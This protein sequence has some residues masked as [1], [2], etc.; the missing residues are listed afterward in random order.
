MSDPETEPGGCGCKVGRV[1]ERYGLDG[2]DAE[3]AARWTVPDGE[4]ASL[5]ELADEFNRRVAR[6]ALRAAGAEPIDGEAANTYRVLDD[7][8]VSS[9]VRV[10]AR[11]RLAR[12]GVDAGALESSFVSH[13]SL[14]T[15]FVDCL[16]ARAPTAGRP[17][18][19]R[20]RGRIDALQGRLAAVASDSLA[21]LEAADRLALDGFDVLV[22][23]DVHCEACGA[24]HDV[25][26]VLDEGGCPRQQDGE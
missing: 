7:G 13:Q 6:A 24:T 5:R 15:H 19:D 8:D 1:Q 25:H 9:G 17:A 26:A 2:V 3:L 14:H 23:V 12:S 10:E 22:D 18:V 21:R 16:D 20:E 11:D 4:R